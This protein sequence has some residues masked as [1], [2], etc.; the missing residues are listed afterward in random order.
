M[1]KTTERTHTESKLAVVAISDNTTTTLITESGKYVLSKEGRIVSTERITNY[2]A[3]VS[4]EI[5]RIA[6]RLAIG[7]FSGSY[8]ISF[9][10]KLPDVIL[11]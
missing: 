2:S 11:S 1:Q 6:D 4:T 8:L 7:Q 5:E 9:E 3:A 10:G